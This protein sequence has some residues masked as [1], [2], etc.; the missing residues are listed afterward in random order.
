VVLQGCVVTD[1]VY[2]VLTR[3]PTPTFPAFSML[4]HNVGPYD[5]LEEYGKLKVGTC[6][7]EGF[8]LAIC[9]I[10]Q[11]Q[12]FVV[13]G[14]S[15][16]KKVEKSPLIDYLASRRASTYI[17]DLYQFSILE[18]PLTGPKARAAYRAQEPIG[19]DMPVQQRD[20]KSS[21]EM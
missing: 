10:V 5:F 18:S 12:F 16:H 2:G 20:V 21:M 6:Y 1:A 13:T 8:R 7:V 4:L 17:Q 9:Q 3:N 15:R 11:Y 14:M 19:E